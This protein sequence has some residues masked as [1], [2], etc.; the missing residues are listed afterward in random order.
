MKFWTAFRSASI[1]KR[2]SKRIAF[3]AA[4][5]LLVVLAISIVPRPVRRHNLAKE[6]KTQQRALPS[7]TV[8]AA[9]AVPPTIDLE[10]SGTMS[11]LTEAPI[12]ARA[13]GHLVKRFVDIGDRVHKGRAIA[14][15][16]SPDPD[17]QV[18]QA[19]AGL[20]ESESTLEQT[21]HSLGQARANQGLARVTAQR[22][23]RLEEKGAVSVRSM[24][25]IRTLYEE[26][27][28]PISMT[29]TDREHIFRWGR[30]LLGLCSSSPG[31]ACEVGW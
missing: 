16:D 18:R 23:A 22:W 17:Q 15:I 20:F 8:T 7:V 1:I 30:T 10:L 6:K 4:I 14:I 5:G 28:I 21:Q 24:A 31:M 26:P 3:W 29:I 27:S 19:R 9:K 25:P 12:L 13:D 11:A 2:N